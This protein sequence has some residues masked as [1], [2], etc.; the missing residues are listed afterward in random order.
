MNNLR[1]ELY[2]ND[3]NKCLKLGDLAHSVG[4]HISNF[5]F[6]GAL[7]TMS[8]SINASIKSLVENKG[9]I[10]IPFFDY[11]HNSFN[12][13]NAGLNVYDLR[14]SCNDIRYLYTR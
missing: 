4:L 10:M 3:P 7:V 11:H 13:V 9:K 5:K 6:N 8:D 2:L 1:L 12:V 14:K